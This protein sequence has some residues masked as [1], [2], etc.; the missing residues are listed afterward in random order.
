MATT[1]QKLG[2]GLGIPISESLARQAGLK[3]GSPV[4]LILREGAIIIRPSQ[5]ERLA[6]LLDQMTPENLHDPV[7]TGPPMGKETW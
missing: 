3:A 5:S 7:D 2:E 6:N 1:I 4:D